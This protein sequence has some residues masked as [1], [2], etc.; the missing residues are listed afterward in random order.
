MNIVTRADIEKQNRRV[1]VYNSLSSL[2]AVAASAGGTDRVWYG[3]DRPKTQWI[4]ELQLRP[5]DSV[6]LF[7]RFPKLCIASNVV[8]HE[9]VWLL[10]ASNGVQS[11][12]LP[13][14]IW[15]GPA[16][17]ARVANVPT[18][19]IDIEQAMRARYTLGDLCAFQD[20][21]VPW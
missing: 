9:G 19:P 3:V 6:W 11:A 7:L 2:L 17:W 10:M 14:E 12:D 8:W 13:T 16:Q 15:A 20:F 4:A 21:E 5:G 1:F 18:E